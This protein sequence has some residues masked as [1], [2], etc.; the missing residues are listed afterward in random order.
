MI[1]VVYTLIYNYICIDYLSCQ[2]KTLSPISFNPE[3]KDT[4][5]NILIGIGIPELLLNLLSCH[6]FMKK[7]NSNVILN[8][9]SRLIKNYLSKVFSVIE[10]KTNQLSLISNDV[11]LRI[12]MVDQLDT[13]YVMI[14]NK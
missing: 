9:R 4:L 13:D 7:P 3:F 14:K 11:K 1:C 8:C 2:S 12:N 5:F 10:K 6:G